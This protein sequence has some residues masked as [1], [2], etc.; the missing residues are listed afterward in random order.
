MNDNKW[1]EEKANE[2]L[3]RYDRGYDHSTNLMTLIIEALLEA[4]RRGHL[5]GLELSARICEVAPQRLSPMDISVRLRNE[6]KKLK[7]D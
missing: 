5:L 6:I 3:D 7:E 4:K 2:L 1:A